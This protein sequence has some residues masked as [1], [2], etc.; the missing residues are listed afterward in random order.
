MKQGLDCYYNSCTDSDSYIYLEMKLGLAG[1]CV[2]D[3]LVKKIFS[4]GYFME[5][6]EKSM[7]IFIATSF[8]GSDR[9]DFDFVDS[10][11]K[12]CVNEGIFSGEMLEK[13]GILTSEKIQEDYFFAVKRRKEIS[14]DEKYLLISTQKL[15]ELT[16]IIL[17]GEREEKPERNENR[18]QKES[19][20]PELEEIEEYVK[21]NKYTFSARDFKAYY[22]DK[23]W[24]GNWKNSAQLWQK[25]AEKLKPKPKFDS[26]NNYVGATYTEEEKKRI[27]E[28]NRRKHGYG[29]RAAD[30]L[31]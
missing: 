20:A 29:S 21:L 17:E 5:Y 11:V 13:Y 12:L 27:L 4:N 30:E 28:A 6:S 15:S 18:E 26:F 7:E 31:N 10:V 2:A 8:Y 23:G 25:N 16:G 24:F 14:F 19:N 1:R 9:P 3:K 22:D